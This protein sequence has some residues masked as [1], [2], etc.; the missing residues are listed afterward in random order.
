MGE[1]RRSWLWTFAADRGCRATLAR[2]PGKLLPNH[3]V[4]SVGKMDLE[5]E[6]QTGQRQP[7]HR[8]LRA[9]EV[10]PPFP[11]KERFFARERALLAKIEPS[12]AV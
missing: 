7:L 1:H 2:T 4:S 8:C 11:C 6:N 10:S 5:L 12:S 9:P 3:G